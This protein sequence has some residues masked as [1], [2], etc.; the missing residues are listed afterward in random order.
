MTQYRGIVSHPGLSAFQS[1]GEICRV[2]FN[3][4]PICPALVLVGCGLRRQHWRNHGVDFGTIEGV[5]RMID[6]GLCDGDH[7]RPVLLDQRLI[8][9]DSPGCVAR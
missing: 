2:I 4:P 8:G 9:N 7:D 6:Q 5:F 1:S 3:R